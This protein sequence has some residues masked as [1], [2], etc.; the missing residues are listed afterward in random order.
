MRPVDPRLLRRAAVVRVLLAVLTGLGVADAVLLLVQATLLTDLVSRLVL[1]PRSRASY[2]AAVAGL[3][4]ASAGRA[5]IAWGREAA[6]VRTGSRV[7]ALLRL[8]LLRRLAAG[9]ARAA[10]RART[11][12]LA[13]VATRGVDAL[14]GYFARYLPQLVLACVVPVVV[15]ARILAADPVSALV[16]AVTVPLIPVFMVLVGLKTRDHMALRWQALERLGGHFLEVVAG[17]PTLVAFG[18]AKRQGAAIRRAADAHRRATMRTLRVAFLSSLVLELIAMLSVA[19]VAVGIG[20]RL[21]EGHLDLR[22]GLLVLIC[23]PEVYLPLRQ[24]GARYHEAAEGLAVADRILSEVA[25]AEHGGTRD[26]DAVGAEIRIGDVVVAPGKVTGVVGPSGAGKTTLVHLLLGFDRPGEGCVTDGG[27]DL[28]EADLDRRA[29]DR[30]TVDGVDLA[31][32]DLDRWR[33][34]IAWLPQHP[35]LTGDTVADAIRLG[36]PTASAAEVERAALASGIDFPL[37]APL[38]RDDGLLAR[39]ASVRRPPRERC[40]RERRVH[41]PR[42]GV[43]DRDR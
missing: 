28:T 7:K 29:E 24:V 35:V 1:A 16:V 8:D 3:V 25:G 43:R 23:A 20:V 12:E 32:I 42:H 27:V 17:L 40:V 13:I 38:G 21:A 6:A 41:R 34:Q 15:G 2:G 31:E 39:C 30:V 18:R 11:G 9:P 5:V 33:A 22:T 10:D 14:D 19:M 36:A 4:A 37:D 26:V